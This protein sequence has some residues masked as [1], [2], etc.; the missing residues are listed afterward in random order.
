MPKK[1]KFDRRT[2]PCPGDPK[3]YVLVRGKYR[4]YWRLKRGTLK[5]AL[6]NDVLTRSAAITSTSNR[7]AKQM[8]SLL[9]VFTQQMELG[10]AITL[11]A[12]AFKRAYLK[13]RM[14]FRFIHEI[15]FQENYPIRKLFTGPVSVTMEEGKINLRVSVGS[16]HVNQL[17][18]IAVGYRV[19]AI[20]LHGDPA[21]DNGLKIETDESEWYTFEGKKES[22]LCNLSLKQPPKNKPWMVMVHI[23]CKMKDKLPAGPRYHRLWVEKVG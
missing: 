2:P 21:K 15:N 13:G 11:A 1:K 22:F 7:A 5:P 8:M 4:Y 18:P 3:D 23:T 12:G 19:T 10:A 20:L 17:S 6:L 14:D 9:S 16:D